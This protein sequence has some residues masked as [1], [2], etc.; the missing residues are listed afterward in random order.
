MTE[1]EII[2]ALERCCD[3]FDRIEEKKTV[4]EVEHILATKPKDGKV[5]EE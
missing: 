3:L 5:Q 4:L 2:E 1:Q